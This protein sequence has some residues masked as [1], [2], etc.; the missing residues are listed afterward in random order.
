MSRRLLDL[1]PHIIVAVEV[2][3]IRYEVEG[4]LVVLNFRVKAGQV[5]PVGK[6]FFVNLAEVLVAP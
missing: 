1:F 5:E 4:I 6:V 3:D 2:E